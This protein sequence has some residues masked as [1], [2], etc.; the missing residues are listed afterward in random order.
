MGVSQVAG[1][2][3]DAPNGLEPRLNSEIRAAEGGMTA[4]MSKKGKITAVLLLLSALLGLAIL[5]TDQNLWQYQPLHAYGLAAFV[6]ID[7]LVA[8][9]VV[10]RGSKSALRIA[11][12]WG[13]LQALVMVSDIFTAS[14]F[15]PSIPISMTDFA[16]YL[17]GLGSYDSHHI[18]YLFPSLFVVNLLVLIVGMMEARRAS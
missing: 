14:P 1:A 2:R 13:L 3:R 7:L 18:P 16:N 11:G 4:P 15:G 12:I 8:G 9:M 10:M 5:G 6:V 17:F